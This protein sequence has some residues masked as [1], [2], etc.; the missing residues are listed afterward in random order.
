MKSA[1]ELNIML[2][3]E[4]LGT[5]PGSKILSIAA[6]PFGAIAQFTPAME[7]YQ[8]INWIYPPELDFTEDRSTIDWWAKQSPEVKKEAFSGINHITAVLYMFTE[9]LKNFKDVEILLWGKGSDFD[10]VLLAAAYDRCGMPLPWKFRNNRCFRTL[11]A[12]APEIKA[13]AMPAGE[14]AHNALHDARYQARH[15]EI[16]LR[17]LQDTI[18]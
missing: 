11:A 1:N 13:P 12:L 15:A 3:L 10:N 14:T 7:F 5:T 9:Y 8:K 18:E 2:D 4:T 17:Y 6:V 16:L